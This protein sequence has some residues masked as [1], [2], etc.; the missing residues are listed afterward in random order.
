MQPAHTPSGLGVYHA[1]FARSFPTPPSV[2]LCS[3]GV[4]YGGEISRSGISWICFLFSVV[5]NGHL[6]FTNR[7]QSRLASDGGVQF[8][9][10]MEAWLVRVVCRL[11]PSYTRDRV[12][13]FGGSDMTGEGVRV[14]VCVCV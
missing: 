12:S 4:V 10:G 9:L 14:C 8:S 6:S 3:S 7:S 2:L 5:G 11:I 13:Q 1:G